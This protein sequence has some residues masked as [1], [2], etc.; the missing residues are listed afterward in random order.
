LVNDIYAYTDGN[1]SYVQQLS[2]LV[3]MRTESEANEEI[4]E[5]AKKDLLRQNHAL[6]MEQINSLTSYQLR[7]I[8][9]VMAGRAHE[10]NRKE[11]IDEFELGSSANVAVVKKALQKKEMIDIE[12]REIR[13]SDP[14][15]VQWARQNMGILV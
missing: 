6:F 9:A 14:V 7:F 1:S 15:F 13:F 12:G 8:R 10:I 4:L 11:T 2:W 3:W 5:D